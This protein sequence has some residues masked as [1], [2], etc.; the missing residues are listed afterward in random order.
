M[1]EALVI[2]GSNG[3]GLAITIELQK[4]DHIIHVVDKVKNHILDEYDNI[5]FLSSQP[6]RFRLFIF[7]AIQRH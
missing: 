7:R 2:G 1:K 6:S 5:H 4:K 3:I